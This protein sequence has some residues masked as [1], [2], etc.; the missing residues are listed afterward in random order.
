M[1][2]GC[3][4]FRQKHGGCGILGGMMRLPGRT[5]LAIDLISVYSSTWP[6]LATAYYLISRY[7]MKFQMP[8]AAGWIIF[9][10]CMLAINGLDTGTTATLQLHVSGNKLVD[11]NGSPVVLHG[12]DRPGTEY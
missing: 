6:M 12:V 4:F 2:T 5:F 1:I 10:V 8:R 3:Q 11:I 9:L 7:I